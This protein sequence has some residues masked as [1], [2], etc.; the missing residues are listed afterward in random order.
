M[1]DKKNILAIICFCLIA[2]SALAVFHN[3]T[4]EA[5]PDGCIRIE[6]PVKE[7]VKLSDISVARKIGQT[8]N[9]KG[10]QKE[11]SGEGIDICD[12]LSGY[13]SSDYEEI[14]V[15]SDDEYKAVITKEELEI[16]DNAVLLIEDSV[17]RLYVFQD[18]YSNR[19][20][21]NVKRII[22]K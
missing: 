2:V 5:V 8:F 21:S 14:T 22:I 6:G 19:N 20:V 18:T 3:R 1:K 15:V 16:P 12:L 13:V 7:T 4:R 10:E 17:A 9:K 11:I